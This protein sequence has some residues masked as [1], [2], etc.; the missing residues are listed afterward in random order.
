MQPASAGCDKS[1]GRK[2]PGAMDTLLFS[3]RLRR[4]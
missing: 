4:R 1:A 2:T 3:K